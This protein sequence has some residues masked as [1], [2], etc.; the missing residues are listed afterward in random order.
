MENNLSNGNFS[1]ISNNVAKDAEDQLKTIEN[2]SNDN[3]TIVSNK[4]AEGTEGTISIAIHK[5]TRLRVCIKTYKKITH[6]IHSNILK[7]QLQ[8][9]HPNI[10]KIYNSYSALNLRKKQEFKIVMEYIDGTELTKIR[11]SNKDKKIFLIKQLLDGVNYLHKNNIA[12]CDLKPGN[13]M[14]INAPNPYPTLKIVDLDTIIFQDLTS[15]NNYVGTPQYIAPEICN[16]VNIKTNISS[17][18]AVKADLWS[19]GCVIYYILFSERFVSENTSTMR[20]INGKY[21]N[22]RPHIKIA[23]DQNLLTLGDEHFLFELLKTNPAD[24]SDIDSVLENQL[25]QNVINTSFYNAHNLILS[26]KDYQD[27]IDKT[28]VNHSKSRAILTLEKLNFTGI[29]RNTYER[30]KT[31]GIESIQNIKH[32]KI[33]E[34]LKFEESCFEENK[35]VVSK[36]VIPRSHKLT[37]NCRRCGIPCFEQFLKK[38]NSSQLTK[39]L[40]ES[41]KLKTHIINRN[42]SSIKLHKGKGL[43]SGKQYPYFKNNQQIEKMV[44]SS[45]YKVC[46]TCY[47]YANLTHLNERE[48]NKLLGGNKKLKNKKLINGKYRIIH[49]GPKGGKFYVRIINGKKKKIYI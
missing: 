40:S 27:V 38:V 47:S 34:R 4:F 30:F 49:T 22:V 26:K 23:G 44:N 5:T 7:K 24:R 17:Y 48:Y 3:F 18:S 19:T 35:C 32:L 2:L 37:N 8:L 41:G 10:L 16:S 28:I 43:Y 12:H 20:T 11:I 9:N 29:N 39:H 42:L 31:N 25:L 13:I 36:V 14:I 1:I 15:R 46:P 45:T 21:P 6:N 33:L